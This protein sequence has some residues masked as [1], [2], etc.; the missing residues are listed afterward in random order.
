MISDNELKNFDNP[1]LNHANTTSPMLL[2]S[3]QIPRVTSYE[4]GFPL[5]YKEDLITG[6]LMPDPL[7]KD[8]QAI[9]ANIKN[10][11]LVVISGCAHA[12]IINTIRYAKHLTGIDKVFAIVGGFHL[13]GGKI[14]EEAIEPTISELKKI[15][16]DYLVPCHCT[17]WKATNRIIQEFPHKFLQSTVCATFTFDS[18]S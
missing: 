4:I 6:D 9:V 17:G 10:K 1:V 18:N 3:G 12:G 7:V 5:Q 11:G 16:P 14:Y 2:I 13:T 15:D 8:D